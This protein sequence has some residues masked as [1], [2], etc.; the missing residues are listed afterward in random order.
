MRMRVQNG[1]PKRV[2]QHWLHCNGVPQKVE[3]IENSLQVSEARHSNEDDYD[4]DD[5]DRNNQNTFHQYSNLVVVA[6]LLVY[7]IITDICS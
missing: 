1:Y 2:S 5:D 3:Q 6:V 4:G 7:T